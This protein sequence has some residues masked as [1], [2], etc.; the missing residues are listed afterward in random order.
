[1][2]EYSI[3]L[4]YNALFSFL[5]INYII[6]FGLVLTHFMLN[7]EKLFSTVFVKRLVVRTTYFDS[8]CLSEC[9]TLLYIF[10]FFIWGKGRQLKQ[11]CFDRS[12][13]KKVHFQNS[14]YFQ[15]ENEY[16]VYF[17][18]LFFMRI[19]YTCFKSPLIFYVAH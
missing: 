9:F 3:S 19:V 17:F 1:M 13:G 10:T 18:N 16:L 8:L 2:I 6:V 5:L 15:L 7:L 14:L 11:S 12:R 4:S